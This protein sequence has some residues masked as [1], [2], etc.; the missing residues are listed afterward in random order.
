MATGID[1]LCDS[2]REGH[3]VLARHLYGK[4]TQE[5]QGISLIRRRLFDV[6]DQ[7]HIN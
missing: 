6:I 7:E 5:L 2:C 1:R 4:T 3:V